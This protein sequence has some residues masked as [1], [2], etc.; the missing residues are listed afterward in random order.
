[1]HRLAGQKNA[2]GLNVLTFLKVNGLGKPGLKMGWYN[3]LNGVCRWLD[4]KQA[5]DPLVVRGPPASSTV[6]DCTDRTVQ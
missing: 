4:V 1:M 6:F 3:N 2:W 5:A